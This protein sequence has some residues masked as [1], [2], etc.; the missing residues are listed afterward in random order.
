MATTL[1][2]VTKFPKLKRFKLDINQLLRSFFLKVSFILK[3]EVL[4]SL[5][6]LKRKLIQ[7]MFFQNINAM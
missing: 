1:R 7:L 5:N 3:I 4:C 6:A 2:R